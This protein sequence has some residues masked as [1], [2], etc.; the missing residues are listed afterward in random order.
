MMRSITK[1]VEDGSA[2]QRAREI[3]NVAFIQ[4]FNKITRGS[5][6]FSVVARRVVVNSNRTTVLLPH[7]MTPL[8][9]ASFI[10]SYCSLHSPSL[11]LIPVQKD[12]PGKLDAEYF[13]SHQATEAGCET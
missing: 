9:V 13:H 4:L 8:G 5:L 7:H 12:I 6:I 1:S 10:H 3:M 11:S 2:V